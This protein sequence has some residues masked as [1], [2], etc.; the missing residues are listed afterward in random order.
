MCSPHADQTR[1]NP[2]LVPYPYVA[3]CD[4]HNHVWSLHISQK[5]SAEMCTDTEL[6]LHE[7]S[8]S[9]CCTTRKCFLSEP[10]CCFFITFGFSIYL[11][12]YFVRTRWFSLV[13]VFFHFVDVDLTRK[14]LKLQI[15]VSRSRHWNLCAGISISNDLLSDSLVVLYGVN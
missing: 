13:F 14:Y 11:F 9:P 7:P 12:G 5:F 10:F 6:H 4:S 8:Y 3:V 1:W 15:Y 2:S